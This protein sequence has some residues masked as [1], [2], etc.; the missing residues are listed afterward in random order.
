MKRKR[1][2]NVGCGGDTYGTDRVDIYPSKTTTTVCDI[3]KGFTLQ[4]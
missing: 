3:E 1:I 2:L 4:K